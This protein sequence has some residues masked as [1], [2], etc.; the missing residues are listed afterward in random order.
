MSSSARKLRRIKQLRLIC[1]IGSDKLKRH[2][3]LRMITITTKTRWLMSWWK[4]FWQW[5]MRCPGLSERSSYKDLPYSCAA[6]GVITT[7]GWFSGVGGASGWGSSWVESGLFKFV[8]KSNARWA[9]FSLDSRRCSIT[10]RVVEIMSSWLTTLLI[11]EHTSCGTSCKS[12]LLR[13]VSG[14]V[15]T[16]SGCL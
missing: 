7:A 8:K 12:T 14:I 11:V 9:W 3:R 13:A 16:M 2:K 10:A 1:R 4:E 15:S 6:T 5:V